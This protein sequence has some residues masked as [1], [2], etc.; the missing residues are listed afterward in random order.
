MTAQAHAIRTDSIGL[1]ATT[2]NNKKGKFTDM[3]PVIPGSV[4]FI[5]EVPAA[6]SNS[7]EASIGCQLWPWTAA[8]AIVQAA[9]RHM[10]PMK[11][12]DSRVFTIFSFLGD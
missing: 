10:N 6:A 1:S 9:A 4:I 11:P 12:L 2:A 8:L 5:R 3:L 7:V